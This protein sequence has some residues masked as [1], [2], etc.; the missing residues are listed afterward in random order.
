MCVKEIQV[1]R[2]RMPVFIMVKIYRFGKSYH[3][4]FFDF[5]DWVA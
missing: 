3:E 4:C 5:D 1:T 2:T